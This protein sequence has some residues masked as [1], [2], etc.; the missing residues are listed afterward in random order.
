MDFWPGVKT[1]ERPSAPFPKDAPWAEPDM[2]PQS[3]VV[4]LSD[5]SDRARQG[6]PP[7]LT[8]SPPAPVV[9]RLSGGEAP[10]PRIPLCALGLRQDQ[11]EML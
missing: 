10:V 7:Q 8:Y 3:V 11:L 1:A 9:N 6:P 2:S 5:L 4:P